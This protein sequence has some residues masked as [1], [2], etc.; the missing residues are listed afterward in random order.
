VFVARETPVELL[1]LGERPRAQVAVGD[2]LRA[3][4]SIRCLPA[5]EDLEQVDAGVA[6]DLDARQLVAKRSSASWREPNPTSSAPGPQRRNVT[7]S[8]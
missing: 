3:E 5:E 8:T 2:N 6:V 7:S 4:C 1:V